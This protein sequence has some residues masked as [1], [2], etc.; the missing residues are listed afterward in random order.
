MLQTSTKFEGERRQAG[1]VTA[2][3]RAAAPLLWPSPTEPSP[4]SRRDLSEVMQ[5]GSGR[6]DV[7]SGSLNPEAVPLTSQGSGH[8]Q[9]RPLLRPEGSGR[10]PGV[11][12]CQRL[13]EE[14]KGEQATLITSPPG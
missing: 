8:G 1:Q 5:P 10:E 9:E 14:Q 4:E 11:L 2:G 3:F 7:N 6:A 12:G 13:C